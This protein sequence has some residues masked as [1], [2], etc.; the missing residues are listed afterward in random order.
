MAWQRRAVRFTA[1]HVPEADAAIVAARGERAAIRAEGQAPD[2]AAVAGEHAGRLAGGCVPQAQR[3]VFAARG[4]GLAVRAEG[5]APD[6]GLMATPGLT[7]RR[8]AG[9]VPAAQRGVFAGTDQRLAIRAEGDAVDGGAVAL[10]R[11]AARRAGRGV[12]QAQRAAVHGDGGAL[13]GAEAQHRAGQAEHPGQRRRSVECVLQTTIGFIRGAQPVAGRTEQQRHVDR[14]LDLAVEHGA[15]LQHRLAQVGRGG[16][17]QQGLGALPLDEE[18]R[19]EAGE[20]HQHRAHPPAAPDA[21]AHLGR[22]LSGARCGALAEEAQG[23]LEIGLAIGVVLIRPGGIG[24]LARL[25]LQRELQFRVAPEAAAALGMQGRCFAEAAQLPGRQRLVRGPGFQ[26]LPDPHQA[27]VGD[28]DHRVGEQRLRHRRHQERAARLAEDVDHRAQLIGRA[29]HHRAQAG[30]ARRPAHPARI[31]GLVGQGLEEPFAELAL[32]LAA[33]LRPGLLGMPVEGVGHRADRLVVTQLDR[34]ALV[35]RAGIIDPTR[36]GAVQRVLQDR[37]LVGVFTHIV[38]QPCQQH[39]ADRRARHAHRPGDGGAALVSRQAGHEVLAVVDGLGQAGVGRAVAEK[40]RAHRQHHEDRT[41]ALLAHLQQQVHKRRGVVGSGNACPW[42]GGRREPAV[43]EQFLELVDDHEQVDPRFQPCLLDDVDQP[44]PA[45]AQ[46]RLDNLFARHARGRRC[47]ARRRRGEQHAVLRQRVRQR[48]QRIA[49]RPH[50]GD[51]PGRA[52]AGHQPAVQC[53]AQ[54]A[55]DE[56]RLAAARGP[57]HR[58]KTLRCQLVDHR[59]DFRLATEEQLLLV[60]AERPQAGKRMA[61]RSR[62]HG[63][64]RPLCSAPSSASSAASGRPARPSIRP[65]ACMSKRSSLSPVRG[66]DR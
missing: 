48:R 17:D 24:L 43:A 32:T 20:E 53:R 62:R 30:Q 18:D 35:S 56:R 21:A 50:H 41:R 11:R 51:A 61:G 27:F 5:D 66:S 7:Q 59:V 64:A 4:H 6:P 60:G 39:R 52:G 55:V 10:Q 14:R 15:A 1:G 16:L 44:E 45:H 49:A 2:A 25:P 38:D 36:P 28:V 40:V 31:G 63:A 8:A 13:V 65:G 54:A 3:R 46:G 57:Q 47:L 26:A 58:E 33:Q 23:R 19:A 12:P 29:L 34:A 42:R 22:L 37:Q 9:G